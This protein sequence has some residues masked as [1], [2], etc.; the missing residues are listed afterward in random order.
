MGVLI[1]GAAGRNHPVLQEEL[2][3]LVD[4]SRRHRVQLGH[5]KLLLGVKYFVDLAVDV[6]LKSNKWNE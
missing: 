6:R 2:G 1:V 3:T 4:V 5:V